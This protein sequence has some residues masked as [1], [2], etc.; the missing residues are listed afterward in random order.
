MPLLGGTSKELCEGEVLLQ[1]ERDGEP[2]GNLHVRR[3][4]TDEL[5]RGGSWRHV[6][7]HHEAVEMERE[8]AG[9]ILGPR[10]LGLDEPV[11]KET[12]IA[13]RNPPQQP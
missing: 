12:K 3:Q 1:V 8:M 9:G 13:A 10:L 2:S 11:V 4:V 7:V 6:P 5:L